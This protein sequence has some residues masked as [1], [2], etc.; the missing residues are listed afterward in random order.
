[1][2]LVGNS[3]PLIIGLKNPPFSL[4]LWERDDRWRTISPWE[5]QAQPAE[6]ELD[7][8]SARWKSWT[9][10]EPHMDVTFELDLIQAKGKGWNFLNAIPYL[11][12]IQL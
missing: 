3:M 11:V 5:P 10:M 12:S 9:V 7:W 4:K 8:Q 6:R 2:K 1:M